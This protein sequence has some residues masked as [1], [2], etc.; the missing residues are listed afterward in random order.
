MGNVFKYEI[1]MHL[2]SII[3]WCLNIFAGLV[4]LMA[5]FPAFGKDAELLEKMYQYY[6]EELLKAF[7]M[8]SSLTLAS[9]LGYFAF[10]FAMI[11]LFLAIQAS[12]YGFSILSVEERELTA[13][14]LLSKPVSRF[15]ILSA[16]FLAAFTALTATNAVTWLGSF[17]SIELFRG[18]KE[19]DAKTLVTLLSTIVLFQ[20]VFLSIGMITSVLVRKIRSVLS[21]SLALALGTY[22]LNAVRSIVGGDL[23]GYF[24]PFYHFEA[25][26][27]L[28]K[29]K[30][31]IPMASIS[32]AIIVI[33][34]GTSAVLYSKRDIH[35]L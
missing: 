29:G 27:I 4:I 34:L 15:K 18:G 8:N 25:V 19:Y 33:A 23:L 26:S 31:N 5:F 7:G 9:A 3:I 1:K 12:N 32:I 24:T 17:V 30:L 14:Y 13:D 22:M 20:L 16:K 35:S 6:P 11:Q 21:Y 10:C 28:D 2:K